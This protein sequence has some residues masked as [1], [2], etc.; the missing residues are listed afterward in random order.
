MTYP[1]KISG[2]GSSLF[3]SQ[4]LLTSPLKFLPK[5]LVDKDTVDV[6]VLLG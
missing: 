4:L 1:S 3:T 6:V 2:H 5:D